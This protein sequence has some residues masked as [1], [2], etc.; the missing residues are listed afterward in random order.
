MSERNLHKK[1]MLPVLCGT[2]CTLVCSKSSASASDSVGQMQMQERSVVVVESASLV[3]DLLRLGGRR[4]LHALEQLDELV[5]RELP[6][7]GTRQ[8]PPLHHLDDEGLHHLSCLWTSKRKSAE[9]SA[10]RLIEAGAQYAIEKI[11]LALSA[12]SLGLFFLLGIYWSSRGGSGIWI[13]LLHFSM[14]I[15]LKS[16]S[17][18][19][20]WYSVLVYNLST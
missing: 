13:S 4:C 1:N 14:I 2:K 9:T 15:I 6:A 12:F 7:A 5:L 10:S 18:I 16:K 17:N 11:L 3:V 20:I 19:K 8:L